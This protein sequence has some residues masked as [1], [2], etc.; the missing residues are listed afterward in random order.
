MKKINSLLALV[1]LLSVVTVFAQQAAAPATTPAPAAVVVEEDNSFIPSISLTAAWDTNYVSKGKMLNP[2]PVASLDVYAELMGVY[3]EIWSQFDMSGYNRPDGGSEW[4]D[5]NR[6]YRAEEIDYTIGYYYTF[7]DLLDDL[8]PVTVDINWTYYQYPRNVDNM[9]EIPLSLSLT[10]DNVLQSFVGEDSPH[11]LAIGAQIT[12]DL[13]QYYWYGKWF[14]AYTYAVNDKLSIGLKNTWYWGSKAFNVA[15]NGF[16]ARALNATEVRVSA[17]Y[18]VCEHIT[19][20]AYVAGAWAIDQQNRRNWRESDINN[21]Q[22]FWG[23]V[24]CSYSF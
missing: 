5:N 17:D 9:H 16:G 18:A 19:L 7:D 24:S 15:S 11:S 2:D 3:V 21:R 22:N 23:G 14:E 20:S 6:K 12:Y 8:T 13:E 10:L 1:M 4:Y